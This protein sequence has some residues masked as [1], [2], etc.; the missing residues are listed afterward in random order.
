M[1][2]GC[3]SLGLC[4]ATSLV[5]GCGSSGSSSSDVSSD[6]GATSDVRVADAGADTGAAEDA[7]FDSQTGRDGA[8]PSDASE[9][10]GDAQDAQGDT[11]T[12][13]A[14]KRVFFSS[15]TDY[16]TG[17]LGGL[18]GADAKCNGLATGAGLGGTW[19]A[20][21]STSTVNAIDHI[22]D[23]GAFYLVDRQTLI[24]PSKAS[25]TGAP[26]APIDMDQHGNSVGFAYGAWTGTTA[27]GVYSGQAC[28]D[29]T[30]DGST[31]QAGTATVAR[32][33]TAPP[34][35]TW[36]GDVADPGPCYT[37]FGLLC[38]EQ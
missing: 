35:T 11:S 24:F 29:W 23:V 25:M 9:S 30:D 7:P 20:W 12:G 16:Y 33:A 8:A 31:S 32:P 27:G 36:G 28:S 34:D 10:Q 5:T 6:A 15:E 26:L 37:E 14:R 2:S 19:K 4:L 13:T 21:V 22:D 18:A 3:S 1:R 38:F 17:N